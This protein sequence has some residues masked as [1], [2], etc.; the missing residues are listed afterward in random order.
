MSLAFAET[1]VACPAS[2][3]A[4]APADAAVDAAVDAR[5]GRVSTRLRL[6][7]AGERDL[8]IAWELAGPADAP[9][10]IA[11]GGISAHRHVVSS[12]AFPEA[13]WW[14][15]QNGAG[16]DLRRV[17]VL[18][19]DWLGAD[20]T[21]DAVI[22][23]TDQADALAAVLDALGIAR[24]AA[25]LGSS[26]G[27]MVGLQ[28]AARHPRRVGR[29]LAI[30]GAT[31]RSWAS[32][33]QVMPRRCS[34]RRRWS[35]TSAARAR[36]SSSPVCGAPSSTCVRRPDSVTRLRCNQVRSRRSGAALRRALAASEASQ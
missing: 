12:A 34:S 19:I 23:S 29:L 32:S 36:G 33:T 3:P 13:G 14:E 11:A 28:F 6:R 16:I 31:R 7:H 5:R 35:S 26:Y 21:L 4:F 2:C 1:P 30:S 22:D 24:V 8:R 25:F 20:G 18:A 27:A 10:V 17:R 9:V 15:G